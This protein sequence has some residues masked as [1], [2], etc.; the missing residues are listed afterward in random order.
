MDR[1]VLFPLVSHKKENETPCAKKKKRIHVYCCFN[2]REPLLARITFCLLQ[3]PQGKQL[4]VWAQAEAPA[5][6]RANH[7][8]CCS[9]WV[10]ESRLMEIRSHDSVFLI[11]S[12]EFFRLSTER[13]VDREGREMKRGPSLQMLDFFLWCVVVAVW[14]CQRNFIAERM[15]SS[16]P[17]LLFF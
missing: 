7:T 17:L 6:T 16:W 10:W 5:W 3:I 4:C 12:G 2:A 11:T 9:P 15:S 14:E 8:L 13:E 1:N